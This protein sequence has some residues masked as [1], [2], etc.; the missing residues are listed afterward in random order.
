MKRAFSLLASAIAFSAVAAGLPEVSNVRLS[1]DGDSRRVTVLYDLS[2]ADAV[3]LFDVATNTASGG[4]GEWVTIAPSNVTAFAGEAFKTVSEGADRRVFFYPDVAW[5]DAAID[6]MRI[7]VKAYPTNDPPAYMVCN[8]YS[9]ERSFYE[10]ADQLPG[11]IDSDDYRKH[12]FL[13]RK[14]P[15]KNVEFQMCDSSDAVGFDSAREHTHR[16]RFTE[17]FY[18]GVFEVTHWQYE[19]CK[20]ETASFFVTDGD[21]RPWC[22]K[23]PANNVWDGEQQFPTNSSG[24]LNYAI[25]NDKFIGKMRLATGLDKYLFMPTETQWEFACRAGT[26]TSFNNGTNQGTSGEATNAGLDKVGRYKGNG[27][28]IGGSTKPDTV[29]CPTNNGTA[30]VGSYAPNA[31]GLYDMHGNVAEWCADQFGNWKTMNGK[32]Y[33]GPIPAAWE[34]GEVL[35][36]FLGPGRDELG[37]GTQ[38]I[39]RGGHWASPPR[40]CRSSSRAVN[41]QF[42]SNDNNSYCGL[43]LAYTLKNEDPDPV[44]ASPVNDLMPYDNTMSNAF[45]NLTGHV[46]Q[47]VSVASASMTGILSADGIAVCG[48][49]SPFDSTCRSEAFGGG[50]CS[51]N[52]WPTAAIIIVR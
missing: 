18:I 41:G 14:I 24:V 22:D 19:Y 25:G 6:A 7:T 47:H 10:S 9:G 52:T 43:R 3:V 12:L 45:W 4:T 15:A 32:T 11:G 35:T 46:G 28:C 33:Q 29:S 48:E 51:L 1:Q 34:G 38:R 21:T 39:A 31:W 8:L 40:N 17:N 30:R 13:M 5:N 36:D 16:A 37:A 49:T 44:P 42:W 2:N 50:D 27:G 23:P 20:K 26:A